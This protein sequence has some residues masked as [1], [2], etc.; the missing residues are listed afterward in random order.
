[1][2]DYRNYKVQV[3]VGN[4]GEWSV[5]RFTVSL[6][7]EKFGRLRS[8]I[9]FGSR[10]RYVPAGT[11]TKL[12]RRGALVMSDTPDEIGDHL[13]AVYRAHGNILIN[14]LGLGIV[15]DLCL[16]KPE[17]QSAT[18]IEASSDVM[19]LVGG[20]YLKKYPLRLTILCEDA[21][22]H[23]VAK[24]TKYQMVW[25]DIWDDICTDNLPD[26]HR[27]HRKYGRVSEWQGS[28]GRELL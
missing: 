15:L 20:F 3:P 7:D 23:S 19:K 8:V 21:F 27:L 17:V 12:T 16:Q 6:E 18:V 22:S 26:M 24:G 13:E 1:M 10:G 11:Y 14:G 9:S 25:H 2:K 5:E 28:W 4:S